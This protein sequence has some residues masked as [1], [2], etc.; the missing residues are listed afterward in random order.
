MQLV[1]CKALTPQTQTSDPSDPQIRQKHAPQWRRFHVPS[2]FLCEW[3]EYKC[4]ACVRL[5]KEWLENQIHEE[6]V[7]REDELALS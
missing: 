6:F 5:P 3:I 2:Q 4:R 7:S 1:N